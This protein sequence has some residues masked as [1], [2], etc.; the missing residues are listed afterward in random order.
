MKKGAQLCFFGNDKLSALVKRYL[1]ENRDSLKDLIT[2]HR[3]TA[4][5]DKPMKIKPEKMCVEELRSLIPNLVKESTFRGQPLWGQESKRPQWWPKTI[6]YKNPKQTSD[7]HEKEL[8]VHGCK[9]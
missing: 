4:D 3:P 6:P 9:H 2:C 8:R 1:K 5:S 7:R